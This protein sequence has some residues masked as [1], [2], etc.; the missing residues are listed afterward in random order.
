MTYHL[1]ES[2]LNTCSSSRTTRHRRTT[3]LAREAGA[4]VRTARSRVVLKVQITSTVLPRVLDEKLSDLPVD[5][6]VGLAAEEVV[7]DT[8]GA[9]LGLVNRHDRIGYDAP[10]P[11]RQLAVTRAMFVQGKT[12]Q[13]KDQ[14]RSTKYSDGRM[15]KCSNRLQRKIILQS[16]RAARPR[17]G[18]P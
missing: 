13:K 3:G 12:C 18:R 4:S 16:P 9:G 6:I 15:T 14:S 11:S 5:G 8:G 2:Q 10:S 1:S 17:H 7:V